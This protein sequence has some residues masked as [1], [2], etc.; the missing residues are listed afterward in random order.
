VTRKRDFYLT[1]TRRIFE[2]V[3]LFLAPSE[4]LRQR[5]IACGVPPAKIIF[6]RYGL[7][8]FKRLPRTR[9]PEPL[10]FGYIGA[11]HAHK[12]IDLLLRA[13]APLAGRAELHIHGSAFG[14]PISESY[15]R[16]VWG[17]PQPSVFFHGPYDN[18]RVSEVLATLDVVVVP[19]QWYEN[20]PLTIQEAFLAGV[21]VVTA[22]CGGM[23]ELVRNGIDGLHF[24]LGDEE[25]LRRTLARLIEDPALLERLRSGIPEVPHIDRQAAAV[26]A[27]YDAL[28]S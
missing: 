9:P 21:P 26:R 11:L 5:Y 22:D 10:A 14:S 20:S 12:G 18:V 17:R 23:A 16:R 27:R 8:P 1:H 25:D 15:W 4:F 19:S 28:L 6:A 13:F 7:R 24:R 2:D 3:D